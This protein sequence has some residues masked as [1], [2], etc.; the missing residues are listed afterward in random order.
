[1]NKVFRTY[2][3]ADGNFIEQFQTTGFNARF[4]ELYLFACLSRTGFEVRQPGAPDFLVT[5]DGITIGI[6]A[7]TT[8]PSSSGPMATDTKPLDEMSEKEVLE[9]T[10]NELPIRLG[11]ALFSKLQKKYWQL[12]HSQNKP[13]IFAIETF[14]EELAW[15]LSDSGLI[16]YLYGL[17]Q[18]GEFCSESGDLKLHSNETTDHRARGK[19]IP[20]A[21]FS[22]EEVKHLSA[23][24]FSN[25]GTHAKFNRM[26]YLCGVGNANLKM[27]RSGYAYN[28]QPY[29]R[30]PSYFS[31][32]LDDAPVRETWTQGL[33]IFHNPHCLH[34]LPDGLLPGATEHRLKKGQLVSTY[35]AWHPMSSTTRVFDLGEV[36]EYLLNNVP[37]IF[38]TFEVSA[39]HRTAF[40]L[41]TSAP[42][43]RPSR[44][45][46]C[47]WF[48]DNSQSFFGSVQE[49]TD[50]KF[51]FEILA[52]DDYFSFYPVSGAAEFKTR[53]DAVRE[54]H[55][56]MAEHLH[57][58]QRIFPRDLA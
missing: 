30:D 52:C 9:Y 2:A 48:S 55:T 32:D 12:S 31:Y 51:S 27:V 26:G 57:R 45:I 20:S 29:A 54:L 47:G 58:P 13:L 10:A 49:G 28:Q 33:S 42:P 23:V 14:H 53:A 16:R 8:N 35:T 22:Q 1:M 21:F 17:G 39:I 38:P 43:D 37:T 56:Q 6:E 44:V 7:T 3:D 50:G 18:S 19:I 36:K 34:P 41:G 25:C 15:G 5:K 4:F 40:E 46:E 11:S 24:I